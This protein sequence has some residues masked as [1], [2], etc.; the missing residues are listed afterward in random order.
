MDTDSDTRPSK[1]F[2]SAKSRTFD[3]GDRPEPDFVPTREEVEQSRKLVEE[4][5]RSTRSGESPQSPKSDPKAAR[6]FS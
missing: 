3:C 6:P 1:L 2:Q 4:V 5:R